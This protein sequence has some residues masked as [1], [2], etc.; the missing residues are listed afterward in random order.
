MTTRDIALV[1]MMT[2]VTA[3]L[4]LMPA[5]TTPLQPAVPIT[6]QTIGVILAGLLLGP[7]RGAA[8]MA[9]LLLLAAI[10]VPVLSGGKS[11]LGVFAG[12]TVGYLVGFV[13]CAAVAGAIVWAK[14][15]PYRLSWGLLAG[16]I[17]AF[18][19]LYL[20]GSIGLVARIDLDFGAALASN[21]AFMP[22]DL[23]KLV[24]AAVIADRVHAAIPELLEGRRK[25]IP[26]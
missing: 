9:L 16:F 15:R 14:G 25:H 10:G 21:L 1:A 13:A 12:P 8:S 20:L 22:G 18:P 4:G 17:G 24:I 11:G 7:L 5:F 6:A 2:A 26:A 3:V 23:A 19:V